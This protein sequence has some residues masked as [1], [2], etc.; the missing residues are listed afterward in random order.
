[1]L[2]YSDGGPGPATK[3]LRVDAPPNG[4]FADWRRAKAERWQVKGGWQPDDQVQAKIQM[5]GDFFM[6]DES[7]VPQVQQEMRDVYNSFD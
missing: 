2:Y 6:I 3:L 4:E 5:T 1:M 7:Q